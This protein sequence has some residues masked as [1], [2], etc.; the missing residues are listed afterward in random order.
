[1]ASALVVYGRLE[2]AG[3]DGD[4]EVEIIGARR[5]E[6]KRPACSSLDS[7]LRKASEDA[8]APVK[9]QSPLRSG[10]ALQID[11]CAKPRSTVK[12]APNRSLNSLSARTPTRTAR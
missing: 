9:A 12:N 5:L 6:R 4:R 8:C 3:A 2:N 1:L 11:S 10:S 7:R